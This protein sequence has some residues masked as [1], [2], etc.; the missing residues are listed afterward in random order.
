M[1]HPLALDLAVDDVRECYGLSSLTRAT[2]L[3]RDQGLEMP[4]LPD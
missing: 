3:G 1:A 4:M 2:M